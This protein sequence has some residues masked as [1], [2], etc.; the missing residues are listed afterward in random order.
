MRSMK[1]FVVI[2]VIGLSVTCAVATE[3]LALNSS[4][5]KLSYSMGVSFV[6]DFKQLG[7]DLDF[8]ALIQGIKDESSGT[9]L[10]ID[11]AVLHRQMNAFKIEQQKKRGDPKKLTPP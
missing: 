2:L 7:Q 11:E 4:K 8:E 10:L 6:R 3:P 5:A 1:M 9:K